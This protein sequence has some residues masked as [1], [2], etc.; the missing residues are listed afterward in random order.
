MNIKERKRRGAER[1][2]RDKE[3]ERSVAAA[4]RDKSD[5]DTDNLASGDRA[6][7]DTLYR[8]SLAYMEIYCRIAR[9]RDC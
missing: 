5:K 2:R 6:R 3:K 1:T 9:A 7:R 4:M 8:E